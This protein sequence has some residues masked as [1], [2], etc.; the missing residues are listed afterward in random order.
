MLSFVRESRLE[1]KL[2]PAMFS[3]KGVIP[4]LN[5]LHEGSQ[6]VFYPIEIPT[7]ADSMLTLVSNNLKKK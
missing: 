6:I 1:K 5:H 7:N 3:Q 4:N 2:G